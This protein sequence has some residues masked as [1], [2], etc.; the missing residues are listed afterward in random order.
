[1]VEVVYEVVVV[2]P[3]GRAPT[4]PGAVVGDD[5]EEVDER[6]AQRLATALLLMDELRVAANPSLLVALRT[7]PSS[8]AFFGT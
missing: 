4:P 2:V 1:M 6:E 5:K 8:W 7:N 3:V